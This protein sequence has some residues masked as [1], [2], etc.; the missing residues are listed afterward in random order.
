MI[1]RIIGNLGGGH[2]FKISTHICNELKDSKVIVKKLEMNERRE[3]LDSI[4]KKYINI[5]QKGIW[6]WEKFIHYEALNDDMAW[7]YIK[8]FVKDNECIMFFNQEEE[9]EMFL[10]QS[11]DDLN[12]VLSETYGFEFYITNKQC[13]YLLCFSHHNILYGCGIAEK[14]IHKLRSTIG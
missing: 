2:M 12:Y 7:S 6:L 9:K 4:L 10:I 5:N 8:D 1:F 3:I 14:W 13:S 11:G